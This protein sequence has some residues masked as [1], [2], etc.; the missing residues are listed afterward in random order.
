M[1]YLNFFDTYCIFFN[2]LQFIVEFIVFCNKSNR[3]RVCQF[4]HT[5]ITTTATAV[6]W[7]LITDP[8]L[9]HSLLFSFPAYCNN[10]NIFCCPDDR[11]QCCTQC[12]CGIRLDLWCAILENC[13]GK[14]TSESIKLKL[15]FIKKIEV[16]EKKIY[17]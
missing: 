9:M 8:S 13:I 3:N 6:F 7:K 11:G 17:E 2:F 15:V 1:F 4:Q 12:N 14:I 10:A 16:N 5:R